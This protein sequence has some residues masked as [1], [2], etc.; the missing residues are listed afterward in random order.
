V[1]KVVVCA[2]CLQYGR[3]VGAVRPARVRPWQAV[4]HAF[5]RA[6]ARAGFV[7]HGICASCR[8]RLEHELVGEAGTGA[9]SNA[10]PPVRAGK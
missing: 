1:P 9:S 10:Q 6:A 5:V 7:S 8:R 4:S 3:P 2:W